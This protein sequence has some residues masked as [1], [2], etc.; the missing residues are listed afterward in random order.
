MNP[1][2]S[3]IVPTFNRASTLDRTLNGFT[4]LDLHDLT[5]EF[6]VVNNNSS[7]QTQSVLERYR[8]RL[9]L[10]PLFEPTPG[11]N[12]ALN[13]ALSHG[14]GGSIVVF[15][16]DDVDVDPQWLRSIHSVS[17]R[18]PNYSVFGGRIEVLWP[19]VQRPGWCTSRYVR[20]FGFAEHSYAASETE[21]RV[22]N[23]PFGPN[24]WVRA[25]V[26]K[27]CRFDVEVGPH[28]TNRILGDETLFLAKLAKSGYTA[29]YSPTPCVHHR[30]EAG[31]MTVDGILKRAAQLGRGI[32]HLRGFP[33]EIEFKKRYPIWLL[34]RY[35]ALWM[36]R[37]KILL[38]SLKRTT[39]EEVLRQIGLHRDLGMNSEAIRLGRQLR[40]PE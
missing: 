25:E 22:G 8:N 4:G 1:E 11:K 5:A 7:D 23:F 32:P 13:R 6:I 15:T 12:H 27:N 17:S 18:W 29:L 33:R 2:I 10:T 3:V 9:P 16:D 37:Q 14:P 36:Y 35:L 20:E 28:P 31:V 21:Y 26:L 19:D 38:A 39:D 34:R 40:S 30:I 24:Y